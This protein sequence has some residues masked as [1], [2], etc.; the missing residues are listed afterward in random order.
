[1]RSSWSTRPFRAAWKDYIGNAAIDGLGAV[2]FAQLVTRDVN[3][4]VHAFYVDL[5]DPATKEFL[6][7]IGGEDDGVKGGLNGIDNGRL[8]FTGS[9]SPAP[10][11]WTATA[12]STPTATTPRP[13][14]A[15][16]AASS[17]CSERWCRAA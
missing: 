3:H 1:V 9:A 2:V 4:G 7:G 15:P 13:S 10:T 12:T 14:P 5:R 17:P 11:S 8:H 6:P 16:A